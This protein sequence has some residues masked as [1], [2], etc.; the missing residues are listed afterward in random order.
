MERLS[1]LNQQSFDFHWGVAHFDSLWLYHSSVIV[2]AKGQPFREGIVLDP[3]RNSGMLFW[4]P[5]KEDRYPWKPDP[6]K[7]SPVKH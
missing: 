1:A 4:A 6:E 3:W 7:T 2:T 5:V